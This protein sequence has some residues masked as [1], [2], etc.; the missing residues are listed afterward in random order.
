MS[1]FDRGFLYGDGL[2]ETIR[3]FN[4]QLFRWL[5]HWRRLEEGAAFLRIKLPFGSEKARAVARRLIAKNQMPNALLR[6]TLSRGPGAPGYSARHANDPAFVMS[7]R[8]CPKAQ[9]VPPQWDLVTSSLRLQA[10]D[11]LAR[12][13]TS[14][15]LKQ[16]LARAEAEAAGADE[17]LL[18]IAGGYPVEGTSSN[19]FWI[20]RDVI[21]TPPL[22]AGVLPGVTRAAVFEICSNLKIP[23][24]QTNIRPKDLAR[25]DGLFLT[26]TSL[27]IV[28]GKS[29]DGKGLR[30]SS[31]TPRIAASYEELLLKSCACNGEAER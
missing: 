10:H 20:K 15:K 18:R 6:L 28:E 7:L 5:Q 23:V 30:T 13:K 25:A 3:V 14:N 4:G 21:L 17:A 8:P 24:R 27:G 22:T 12:F 29:L 9:R 19:L 2:F 11:P 31:L 26:L 16:V 1:V